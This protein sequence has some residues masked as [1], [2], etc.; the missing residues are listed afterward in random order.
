MS[1]HPTN[2]TATD[3][4]PSYDLRAMAAHIDHLRRDR[5][6][7]DRKL[8]VYHGPVSALIDAMRRSGVAVDELQPSGNPITT[9]CG[10]DVIERHGFTI[11]GTTN[12]IRKF[13]GR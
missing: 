9:V 1:D 2:Y 10:L 5:E 7:D 13:S 6:E 8:M 3:P 11:V 4:T 12:A